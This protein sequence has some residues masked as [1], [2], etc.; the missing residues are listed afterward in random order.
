M[1]QVYIWVA[2]LENNLSVVQQELFPLC[3]MLYPMFN[4]SWDMV[5]AMLGL[6]DLEFSRLLPPKEFARCSA[7]MNSL[8]MMFDPE[9]VS[10]IS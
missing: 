7:Y 9:V 3:V 10:A 6:I 1:F 2:L 4:V 8:K 5:R